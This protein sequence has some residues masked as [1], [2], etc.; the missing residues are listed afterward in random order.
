MLRARQSGHERGY[1]H[2]NAHVARPSAALSS[3]HSRA[4]ACTGVCAP[5]ATGRRS[6]RGL[7]GASPSSA[8][9]SD[10]DDS[11]H[12]TSGQGFQSGALFTR[13]VCAP[14]S[15]MRVAPTRRTLCI[16]ASVKRVHGDGK[17]G[18]R[19]MNN[20]ACTPAGMYPSRL[21]RPSGLRAA[22]YT[23]H[24]THARTHVWHNITTHSPGTQTQMKSPS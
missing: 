8:L 13:T 16:I 20:C 22:H 9:V 1:K 12:A 21:P 17:I 6:M 2:T 3:G 7:V 4:A 23:T 11:E 10:A 14:T 19:V 24:T 18:R 5:A 15:P